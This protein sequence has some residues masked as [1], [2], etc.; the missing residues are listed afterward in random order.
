MD[1]LLDPC[2]MMASLTATAECK[3]HKVNPICVDNSECL[4]TALGVC[5]WIQ[6]MMAELKDKTSLSERQSLKIG[7]VPFLCLLAC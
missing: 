2:P 1:E 4:G 7:A 6:G 3:L 5:T